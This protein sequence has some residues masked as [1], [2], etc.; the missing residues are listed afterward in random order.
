MLRN[1]K[2]FRCWR[3]PHERFHP[4]C[5]KATVKH[6]KRINVW[7]FFAV[8]GVGHLYREPGIMDQQG[9]HSILK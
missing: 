7:G 1:A 8:H 4:Q 6:G 2:R 5:M 9:Y 3:G